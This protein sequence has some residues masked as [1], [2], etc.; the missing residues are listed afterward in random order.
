MPDD[1]QMTSA[2]RYGAY[3]NISVICN[4][5]WLIH[6]NAKEKCKGRTKS[7]S[8]RK[9]IP[10]RLSSLEFCIRCHLLQLPAVTHLA[11]LGQQQSVTFS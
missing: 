4:K 1:A 2:K 11:I 7:L 6:I 8:F 5:I 3:C 10:Y 9:T